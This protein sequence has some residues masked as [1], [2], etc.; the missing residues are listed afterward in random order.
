MSLIHSFASTAHDVVS[1]LPLDVVAGGVEECQEGEGFT[2]IA[3]R[4]GNQVE[5]LLK[6]LITVIAIVFVIYKAVQ[7]KFAL[8]T[9]L[10]SALVAGLLIWIVYNTDSLFG[11]FGTELESAPSSP[12]AVVEVVA[13]T[14]IDPTII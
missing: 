6:G 4:E 5:G 1:A 13:H 12:P 9:I 3:C 8:G 7:S 2:G 14:S 11:W 10:V